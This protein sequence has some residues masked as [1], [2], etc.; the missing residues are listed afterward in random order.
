MNMR[1]LTV[2]LGALSAFALGACTVTSTPTGSGGT[3]STTEGTGG[4][5]VGGGTGGRGGAGG[6]GGAAGCVKDYTCA[7]AITPPD[8]D[9]TKVCDGPAGDAYDAYYTCVC[10]AAGAC[11]TACGAAYCGGTAATAECTACLQNGDTGCGKQV[12]NCANN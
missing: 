4:G 1:S 7:E 8:G 11:G 12:D 10:E 2:I 3:S 6:S 9:G 5:G